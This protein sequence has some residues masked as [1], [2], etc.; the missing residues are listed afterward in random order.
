[1]APAPGL[2]PLFPLARRSHVISRPL[3][4]APGLLPTFP[5]RQ[6]ES[7]EQP[8]VR[9]V[10]RSNRPMGERGTHRS[11]PTRQARPIEKC[12]GGRGQ[13]RLVGCGVMGADAM[14]RGGKRRGRTNQGLPPDLAAC[15]W[16][17]VKL[18]VGKRVL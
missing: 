6:A 8:P 13:R 3:A 1:M 9:A 12:G 5:A 7:R 16:S 18:G 10:G 17:G 11:P 15:D 4:P 2:L 14:G